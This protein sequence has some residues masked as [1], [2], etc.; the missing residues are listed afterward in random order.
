V[1]SDATTAALFNTLGWACATYY[2]RPNEISGLQRRAMARDL[3]WRYSAREYVQL[4][5]WAVEHRTGI[6][7]V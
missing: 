5:R 2:N 3:S 6:Y 4:Y 7:P 1:F